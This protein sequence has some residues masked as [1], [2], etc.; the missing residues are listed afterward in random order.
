[1]KINDKSTLS[2]RYPCLSHISNISSERLSA[3]KLN[4]YEVI[5][6]FLAV[7]P[8]SICKCAWAISLDR[9]I[10]LQMAS[11]FNQNIHQLLMMAS[12]VMNFR[13]NPVVQC[14]GIIRICVDQPGR[15]ENGCW[16]YYFRFLLFYLP[17]KRLVGKLTKVPS[18][19]VSTK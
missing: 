7:R 8:V 9:V 19:S 10:L 4:F 11:F 14:V 13:L 17:I 3:V 16:L 15:Q 2:T 12:M 18:A 5:T 1:M 6:T